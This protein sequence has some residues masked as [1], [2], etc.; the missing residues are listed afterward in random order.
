MAIRWTI[1]LIKFEPIKIWEDPSSNHGRSILRLKFTLF[2]KVFD[3]S[4]NHH[5]LYSYNILLKYSIFKLIFA[6]YLTVFIPLDSNIFHDDLPQ[7]EIISFHLI[8]VLGALSKS[9][10]KLQFTTYIISWLCASNCL[11]QKIQNK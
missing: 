6:H 10:T 9:P 2:L 7:R 8:M 3:L 1:V 11:Y 5:L 4:K